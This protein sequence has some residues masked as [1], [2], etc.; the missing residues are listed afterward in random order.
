MA[1][2]LFILTLMMVLAA[3]A[4]KPKVWQKANTS[5]EEQRAAYAQCRSSAASESERDYARDQS[6]TRSGGYGGQSTYQKNMDAYQVRKSS[7]D[8]LA[9]CMKLKGY[10]QV[11]AGSTGN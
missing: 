10:R 5:V 9:R 7:K 8:L 4:A 11:P 6:Y 1:K 2:P 3:C